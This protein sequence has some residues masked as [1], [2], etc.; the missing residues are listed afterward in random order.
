MARLWLPQCKQH[1]CMRQ[2]PQTPQS[3]C[4]LLICAALAPWGDVLC[5]Q[6]LQTISSLRAGHPVQQHGNCCLP[7]HCN[8]P[9]EPAHLQLYISATRQTSTAEEDDLQQ[10]P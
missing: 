2:Q 4:I 8:W 9:Q 10:S 3:A 1:L 6:K 5:L 7:T